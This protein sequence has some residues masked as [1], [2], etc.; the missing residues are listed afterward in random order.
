MSRAIQILADYGYVARSRLRPLRYGML[1]PPPNDG[2]RHPVLIIPGVFET[3]HYLRP[4]G[5]RLAA[6]GHPVHYVAALGFNHRPIA[7]TAT[8]LQRYLRRKDLLNVTIVAH[9]KGGLIGKRMLVN[10]DRADGRVRRLIAVNT[11]FSGTNVAR[12]GLGPWREFLPTNEI[13][14][15]LR[16][17]RAVNA[18]IVSLYSTFDQYIPSGSFLEGAENVVLP[19]IGHFGVLGRAHVV[20]EIASRVG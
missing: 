3:W 19:D 13:V 4:V 5:E 12:L 14:A 20:D 10:D 18:S 2:D 9:S 11:P 6:L 8:M 15:A 17:E 7:V 1:P 16:G